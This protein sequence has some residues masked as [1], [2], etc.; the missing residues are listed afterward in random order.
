[1]WS[2]KRDEVTNNAEVTNDNDAL[3]FK[4]KASI[5][6]NTEPDGTKNGVKIAVL[7]KYLSN[8]WRSLE[9]SLINCKVELSL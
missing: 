8:S 5:I 9:M 1:M 4:Y 6:G 2:F 3:S 7:L